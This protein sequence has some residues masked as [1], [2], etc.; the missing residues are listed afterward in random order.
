MDLYTRT[1]KSSGLNDDQMSAMYSDWNRTCMLTTQ[2]RLAVAK[3]YTES[4]FDQIVDV[5]KGK[6]TITTENIKRFINDFDDSAIPSLKSY[7]EVKIGERAETR[8][9]VSAFLGTFIIDK[10][11]TRFNLISNYRYEDYAEDFME[12]YPDSI[13]E[14]TEIYVAEFISKDQNKISFN[15]DQKA[16]E[17]LRK[18]LMF[19]EILQRLLEQ[20]KNMA[21]TDTWNLFSPYKDRDN[22]EIDIPFNEI[23]KPCCDELEYANYLPFFPEQ[24][25]DLFLKGIERYSM[26]A[27]ISVLY[28]RKKGKL[29]PNRRYDEIQDALNEVIDLI[30]DQAG[31]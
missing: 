12:S 2:I 7:E 30:L 19:N 20:F 22:N 29:I 1:K 25:Y 6:G 14:S 13:G 17:E 9:F 4:I 11:L 16:I 27:G 10:I 15:M 31:T 24:I 3:A 5:A 8:K 21:G 18:D 28:Q 23:Y 26:R